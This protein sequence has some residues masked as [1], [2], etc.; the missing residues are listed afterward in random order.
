M[1]VPLQGLS[2]YLLLVGTQQLHQRPP[3]DAQRPLEVESRNR[4]DD[5]CPF[6]EV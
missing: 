3:A 6:V 2:P 5:E 4:S 1:P